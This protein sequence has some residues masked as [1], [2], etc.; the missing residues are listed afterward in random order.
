[1]SVV[2]SGEIRPASGGLVERG[3]ERFIAVAYGAGYDAVVRGFE[4]YQDLLDDIDDVLIRAGDGHALRLLDV[5]CGTGTAAR[6]LA[7]AGH[8]VVGIDVIAHLVSRARRSASESLTFLHGDV[9]AGTSFPDASF[10]ACVS[11]HTLNWHPRPAALLQ[12]CRRVLRPGGHLVALAY[13]RPATLHATFGDVRAS[14]GLGAAF[15]AL[16]W[17]V[18]T[19]LFETCRHYDAR[20]P[21][22]DALHQELT[23]TGYEIVESR[24]VFLA[25]VSR[26][27]WARV[28]APRTSTSP[29]RPVR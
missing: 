26:L 8:E 4:P 10:D 9:A 2:A 25:G 23:S 6:R 3:L 16:R 27:V 12:E 21:D 24:P 17:L 20:Y 15:S 7:E 14:E 19:A 28:A 13:T 1:M 22:V 5:A 18:P 29:R 11:L